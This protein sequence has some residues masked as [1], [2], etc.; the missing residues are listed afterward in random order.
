M[1]HTNWHIGVLFRRRETVST[2]WRVS[3][4][5]ST[6]LTE[7]LRCRPMSWRAAEMRHSNGASGSPLRGL[8][9]LTI[10]QTACRRSLRSASRVT[11][12]WPMCGG[13]NEPPR[14]PMRLQA[15]RFQFGPSSARLVSGAVDRATVRRDRRGGALHRRETPASRP[16]SLI[17]AHPWRP[18]PKRWPR[19]TF[20]TWTGSA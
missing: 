1:I 10:H 2:L 3:S 19:N 16:V 4:R 12:R 15:L 5:A 11:C 20:T 7:I 6:S 8:P 14:S 18:E 9:G 17:I 13:S